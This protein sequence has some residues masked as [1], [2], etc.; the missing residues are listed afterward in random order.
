MKNPIISKTL[1]LLIFCSLVLLHPA[2]GFAGEGALAGE[3]EAAVKVDLQGL[4]TSAGNGEA[5]AQLKLGNMNYRGRGITKDY[6]QAF[7]WYEKAALQENAEA[8]YNLANMYLKG[9]AVPR[10][11]VFSYMWFNLSSAGGYGPASSSL[12]SLEAKMT[13]RQIARAQRMSRELRKK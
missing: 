8:Q 11:Y 7:T 12:D 9:Q 1:L 5:E 13:P 10:D 4:I 6:K 2:C 3:E